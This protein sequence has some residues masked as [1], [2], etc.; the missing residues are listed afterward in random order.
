MGAKNDLIYIVAALCLVLLILFSLPTLVNTSQID[1][2]KYK[3]DTHCN[4]KGYIDKN[5]GHCVCQ[6]PYRGGNCTLKYCPFGQSWIEFP[7]VNHTRYQP[8]VEC[9][10]MGSC[11]M[12]TGTCKCRPGFEGRG[13][14]RSMYHLF[15]S[16]V[17]FM[18]LENNTNT[19]TLTE[20]CPT[21]IVG[22]SCSGHGR[23]LSM[24]E[25]SLEFNGL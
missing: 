23:C 15:I 14:E 21:S 20:A 9:S 6:S 19:I 8:Y 1:I 24:R 12:T 25:A 22:S 11:D 4:K 2:S 16:Y 13:C 7:R 18:L 5:T 17:L 10:N 3:I